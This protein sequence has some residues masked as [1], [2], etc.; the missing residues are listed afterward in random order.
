MKFWNALCI[1]FEATPL[2]AVERTMKF[3]DALCTYFEA[4]PLAAVEIL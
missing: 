4:T 1:N 3:W 2:A